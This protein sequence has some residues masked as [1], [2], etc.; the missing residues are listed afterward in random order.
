ML[1]IVVQA[2]QGRGHMGS[3]RHTVWWVFV[4]FRPICQGITSDL[5]PGSRSSPTPLPPTSVG[6]HHDITIARNVQS[7]F[8]ASTLVEHCLHALAMIGAFR[9]A[10]F[11][12]CTRST[13]THAVS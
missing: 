3:I 2:Q 1:Q 6:A 12:A 4:P 10:Y 5:G 9:E 7:S 8:R 11:S 13:M